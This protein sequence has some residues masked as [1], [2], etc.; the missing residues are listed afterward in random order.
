MTWSLEAEYVASCGIDGL[1]A[2]YCLYL[3]LRSLQCHAG[4]RAIVKCRV[5]CARTR[6]RDVIFGVAVAHDHMFSAEQ[7]AIETVARMNISHSDILL[8]R[9]LLLRSLAPS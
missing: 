2:L 1:S 9:T 4:V 5:L 6:S 3:G 8:E 7:R